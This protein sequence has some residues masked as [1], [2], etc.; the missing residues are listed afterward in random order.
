MFDAV[1]EGIQGLLGAIVGKPA[2][3]VDPPAVREFFAGGVKRFDDAI[4]EKDKR[5]AW[6]ELNFRG[7]ESGL[8]RDAERQATG[9]K[10]FGSG[11]G[12]ADDRGVMARIDVAE[13]PIDGIVFGQD[14][15]G[16][17][18]AA[19]TVSTGAMVETLGELR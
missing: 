15:G 5:V 19:E 3:H 18:L 16:E 14:S 6:L 7:G 10:A 17:T 11:V 8:G 1:H 4:R 2:N 13:A 12:A 9:F